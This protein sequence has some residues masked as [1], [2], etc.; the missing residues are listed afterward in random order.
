VQHYVIFSVH[1]LLK[2][3]YHYTFGFTIKNSCLHPEVLLMHTV[4]FT[5]ALKCDL[6]LHF[7]VRTSLVTITL[8]VC[9]LGLKIN[10][11]SMEQPEAHQVKK[12]ADCH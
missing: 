12:L 11:Q 10:S 6:V 9:L 8:T 2:N 1:P 3:G 7:W 5:V 4:R